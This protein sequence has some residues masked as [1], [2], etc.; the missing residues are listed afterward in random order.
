MTPKVAILVGGARTSKTASLSR[1]VAQRIESA[2]VEVEQIH[3]GELDGQQLLRFD[4]TGA[5]LRR[6]TNTIEGAHGVVVATPIYK[7]SFSGLLKLALD[8]LPQ[9]GL[10]GKVVMPLATAGGLA[11]ALALDYALRP[12][13][14]SMAARHV[15]QSTVVSDV[16]W[17]RTEAGLELSEKSKEMLIL[18]VEHFLFALDSRQIVAALGMSRS[19]ICPSSEPLARQVS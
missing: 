12:V 3:L 19:A 9:F 17:N 1:W 11:H 18:A 16:D 15:V 13:L 14:Q 2:A 6:L 10:A 5:D 8:V 4:M 7:A